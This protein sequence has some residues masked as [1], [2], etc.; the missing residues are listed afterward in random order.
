MNYLLINASPRGR[1]SNSNLILSKLKEGLLRGGAEDSDIEQITLRPLLKNQEWRAYVEK[2][3]LI[4]VCFPLYADMVP[5]I[6][7]QFIEDLGRGSLAGRKLGWISQC[8]F[9]ESVHLE[10]TGR[11]LEKLTARLGAEPAGIIKKGGV[12]GIRIMPD[13][14]TS[15]LFENLQAFGE[16]LAVR[17]YFDP[18]RLMKI[19]LPRL[20]S[21]V[22]QF[23]TGLFSFLGI[24][25]FYW[26]S[27]LK[28]N[29]AYRQRFAKP[30]AP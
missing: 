3:D 30:F 12:E 11:Y 14:M 10:L 7:K 5:G 2:S 28:E 1:E 9:P 17:G 13:I 25:N 15:G 19:A 6:L 16:D 23:F 20:F 26:N 18:L 27:K 4:I 8:G 21:P 24:T 22:K 29:G